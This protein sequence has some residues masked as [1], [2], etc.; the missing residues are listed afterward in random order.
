M[1]NYAVITANYWTGETGQRIQEKGGI[2][3]ACLGAY[4]ISNRHSNAIGIYYLP[5]PLI[6]YELRALPEDKARQALQVL[7]QE[8]FSAY[9]EARSMVYVRNMARFQLG[10]SL[11]RKDKRVRYVVTELEQAVQSGAVLF[12]HDFFNRFQGDYQME[13]TP[14]LSRAFS[15][16]TPI[17]D[18]ATM[19]P[20]M[21][22]RA[23]RR[24]AERRR[25]SKDAATEGPFHEVAIPL[26]D[27]SEYR[28]P[29]A[30]VEEWRRLF[31]G[32]DVD[33]S[34]R[35]I[36]AWNLGEPKKRKTLSGVTKHITG[37]LSREQNR[38]GGRNGTQPNHSRGQPQRTQRNVDAARQFLGRA[39]GE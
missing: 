31:P 3:A 37:W 18:V 8:Q 17:A 28:I 4:L 5:I 23:P 33:Q 2:E 7:A 10:E 32:I 15:A 24:T 11:S 27:G 26:N 9:D 19:A 13:L 21:L 22:D 36:R 16:I 6:C 35:D 12:A 29:V 14:A 38:A 39:S 20:A 25:E 30:H 1:R 34:L